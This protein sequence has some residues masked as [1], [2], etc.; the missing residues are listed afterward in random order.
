MPELIPIALGSDGG[1]PQMSSDWTRP[2]CSGGQRRGE[3][4]E[5]RAASSQPARSFLPLPW[6][7]GSRQG[8]PYLSW[9]SFTL[10]V[11]TGWIRLNCAKPLLS[12]CSMMNS[13]DCEIVLFVPTTSTDCPPQGYDQHVRSRR[14]SHLVRRRHSD[15][16]FCV[17]LVS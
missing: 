8:I 1:F 12:S 5:G 9:F 14:I 16:S 15:S 3:V 17:S 4:I 7:N 6:S 2:R 13:V 11:L 10:V